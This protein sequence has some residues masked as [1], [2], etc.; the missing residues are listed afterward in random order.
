MSLMKYHFCLKTLTGNFLLE[1][2][3]ESFESTKNEKEMK[4]VII[5]II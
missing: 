2:W 4:A 1:W 3:S 5:K